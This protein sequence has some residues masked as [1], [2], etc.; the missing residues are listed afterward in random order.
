MNCSNVFAP[1]PSRSRLL[2]KP[3]QE[4]TN[5]HG[6]QVQP[7]LQR[8]IRAPAPVEF[9]DKLEK[10]QLRGQP[11]PPPPPR[12]KSPN[13]TR[14]SDDQPD[15][16]L[17]RAGNRSQRATGGEVRSTRAETVERER[18]AGVGGG[19][20]TAHLLAEGVPGR[21]LHG[22]GGGGGRRGAARGGSRWESLGLA[23]A[24]AGSLPYRGRRGENRRE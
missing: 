19:E 17:Q 9:A 4:G 15:L 7:S 23:A 21:R 12:G 20:L 11:T 3:P 14:N 10:V 5:S 8:E 1:T 13:V 24:A 6:I 22:G 16:E 2:L 18:E